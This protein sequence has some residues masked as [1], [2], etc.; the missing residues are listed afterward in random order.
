MTHQDHLSGYMTGKLLVAMPH[1]VDARFAQSVI[2]ICGHDQN[3]A[4]GL[5]INKTV[6]S[7]SLRDLVEQLNIDVPEIKRNLP[8]YFGGPVEMGRGFV[9]H[10]ADYKKNGTIAI[11]ET[12]ALT[13]TID[14][15]KTIAEG[16]GPKESLLAL[17]YVG[18]SANQL[19]DEIHNNGWLQVEPDTDLVF[20]D[21]LD[22]KWR[23]AIDKLGVDPSM[24]SGDAGHA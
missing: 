12:M 4:M 19:E 21:P 9:L 5:M 13:A 8:V 7:L 6:D 20:H 17:G 18:W 14:I 3:G 23:K 1:M 24:L 16:G 2:F 11:N 22:R 15:L 10:S